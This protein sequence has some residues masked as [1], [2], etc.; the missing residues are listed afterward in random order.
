MP[1][2]IS[3]IVVTYNQQD[4]VGRTLDSILMQNFDGEFEIIV[5]DDASIDSTREV[6][7]D[8]ANRYPDKIRYIR[9]ESNL[10]LVANYYD[11]IRQADGKYI[12]DCAGDD[13]WVDCNKLQKQFDVMEAE[14]DVSMV[15][16]DWL[17]C[18][19]DGSNIRQYPGRNPISVRKKY[20]KGEAVIQILNNSIM[21]HLCSALYRRDIAVCAMDDF[22]DLMMNP[23]WTSEDLQLMTLMAAEGKIVMLPDVTT[24]YSIG[25]D[26]ISNHKDFVRKFHYSVQ[27]NRQ[28]RAVAAHFGVGSQLQQFADGKTDYFS[29]L[30]F[31]SYSPECRD[32]L[33]E[34]MRSVGC[35][36]G[37]KSRIYQIAMANRYLWRLMMKIHR[38]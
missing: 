13:F 36:G 37:I 16:T 26:S 5:G 3:V 35:R 10:G 25:H 29:A 2:D 32:E 8:Y 7:E 6:C 23:D 1:I 18:N 38:R 24:Y 20:K 12:A 30:A 11:C 4:T 9:R 31:H 15:T 33:K 28:L 14:P 17:C 34:F 21:P 22:P 27:S 19:I